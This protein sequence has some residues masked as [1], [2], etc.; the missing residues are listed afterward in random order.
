VKLR[1]TMLI[2]GDVDAVIAFDYT[3]IFNL[4]E[5]GLKLEDINLL[6]YSDFGFDF[7][8]NSLI[9]SP[10]TIA[11]SPDLVRRVA[12]G[13][14]RAW[15]GAARERYAPIGAGTRR[16]R[17]LKPATERARMD[18]VIDRLILTSSVR[19]NGLGHIDPARMAKG[20]G[21]L[22]D[23]FQLAAAPSLDQVYD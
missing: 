5:N 17:L 4:L 15:V 22:K 20:F 9:V 18:W 8:G 10:E 16:D 12:L 21:V 13:V 3:A 7:P 1:D 14:A 23:G 19:Q 11:K 6:Y 2:K